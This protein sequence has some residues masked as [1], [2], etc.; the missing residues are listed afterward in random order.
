M[1]CTLSDQISERIEAGLSR[2][3]VAKVVLLS[4]QGGDV[5]TRA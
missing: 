2:C 4:G 5:E 1:R 3:V